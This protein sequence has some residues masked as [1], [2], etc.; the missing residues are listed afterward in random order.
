MSAP[1]AAHAPL[2]GLDDDR[3]PP[4]TADPAIVRE[5]AS[6]AALLKCDAVAATAAAAADSTAATACLSPFFPRTKARKHLD[7][8]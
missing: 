7:A 4:E 3:R 6:H 8:S 5:L 1:H 2:E